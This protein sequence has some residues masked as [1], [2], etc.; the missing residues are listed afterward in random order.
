MGG[1]LECVGSALAPDC[2]VM[3]AISH[4]AASR[5]TPTDA[6]G[7]SRGCCCCCCCCCCICFMRLLNSF[8]Q[9]CRMAKHCCSGGSQKQMH[10]CTSNGRA[11]VGFVGAS[12]SA[13]AFA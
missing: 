5:A 10:W 2:R 8:V 1:C 13:T 11:V 9:L 6:C 4:A 12:E 7:R 3:L